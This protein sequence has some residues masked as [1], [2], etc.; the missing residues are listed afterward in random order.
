MKLSPV[1]DVPALTIG[2][3][4]TSEINRVIDWLADLTADNGLPQKMLLLHQFRT[5]MITNRSTLDTSRD[6]LALVVQMDGL[7]SQPAKQATWRAIRAGV[8]QATGEATH[9]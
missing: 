2:S 8:A 6:E 1:P 4:E 5:S 3:K 7:G 9:A